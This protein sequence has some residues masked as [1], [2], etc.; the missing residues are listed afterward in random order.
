[1]KYSEDNKSVISGLQR[2]SKPGCRIFCT[3]DSLPVVLGGVGMAIV[4]TSQ[5]VMTEKK[6]EERGTGGEVLCYIW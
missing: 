2:I 5:G 1:L 3:K 6:C 4:S